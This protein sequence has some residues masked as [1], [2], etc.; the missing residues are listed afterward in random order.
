MH[1]Y[2]PIWQMNLQYHPHLVVFAD[3][4]VIGAAVA[5]GS[6]PFGKY[7]LALFNMSTPLIVLTFKILLPP[8]S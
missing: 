3:N 6:K 8:K 5:N 4:D 1:V 7:L 2:D